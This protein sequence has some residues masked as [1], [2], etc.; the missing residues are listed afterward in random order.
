MRIENEAEVRDEDDN[1]PENSRMSPAQ[2]DQPPVPT[3]RPETVAALLEAGTFH[4]QRPRVGQMLAGLAR[5]L[6]VPVRQEPELFVL[7]EAR[8]NLTRMLP[9]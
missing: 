5:R 6:Q 1:E 3:L 4:V 2:A 7:N 8:A 9:R